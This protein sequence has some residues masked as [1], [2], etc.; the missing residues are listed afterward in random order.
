MLLIAHLL[1]TSISDTLCSDTRGSSRTDFCAISINVY[2]LAGQLVS[3]KTLVVQW[4]LVAD[5]RRE[6]HYLKMYTIFSCSNIAGIRNDPTS[7]P[8]GR[9]LLGRRVIMGLWIAITNL[10]KMANFHRKWT[11]FNYKEGISHLGT[12]YDC[13]IDNRN[14]FLTNYSTGGHSFR[15]FASFVSRQQK[16]APHQSWFLYRRPAT[17]PCY[18]GAIGVGNMEEVI[19]AVLGG[20]LVSIA[21]CGMEVT[22]SMLHRHAERSRPRDIAS[23][24]DQSRQNAGGEGRR[25][26]S[27]CRRMGWKKVIWNMIITFKIR[28]LILLVVPSWPTI[29]IIPCKT[30]WFQKCQRNVCF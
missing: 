4:S 5:V 29:S 16:E 6:A 7:Y 9:V 1:S 3:S 18:G 27:A 21:I 15:V 12:W 2:A 14:G 19:D 24:R 25:K 13:K 23:E 17:G 22:K 11:F 26:Q 28:I 20:S 30:R 8:W 10:T